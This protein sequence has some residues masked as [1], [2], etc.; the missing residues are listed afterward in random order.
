MARLDQAID[1]RLLE[2]REVVR[3]GATEMTGRAIRESGS[4]RIVGRFGGG[5]SAMYPELERAGVAPGVAAEAIERAR[6]KV[7]ERLKGAVRAE[8]SQYVTER[9]RSAGKPTVAPHESVSRKCKV[10]GLMHSKGSHRF[11]GR[12]AYHQTHLFSFGGENPMRKKNAGTGQ[13]FT[14]HGSFQSLIL[15]RRRERAIPGSFIRKGGVTGRYYVMKP[16]KVS[17]AKNPKKLVRIY[18]RVLRIEAQK[19]G[20]HRCDAECKK[21]GHRYF[22]DFKGGKPKMLGLSP[23]EVF[24]VPA[25]MYPI[26]I[27]PGA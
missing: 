14:F 12:G 1:A 13:R 4:G 23:G 7:F 10:C 3:S 24:K 8:L 18:G 16:R 27:V 19:T 15:A 11:H 6:G 20:K 22:H 26:L 5:L 2:I 17:A 9:K 21:C 25:G